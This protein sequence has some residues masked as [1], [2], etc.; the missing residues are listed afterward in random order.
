MSASW[1]D[2]FALGHRQL[3]M[4]LRSGCAKASLARL[5]RVVLLEDVTIN[6]V[7]AA[8]SPLALSVWR[9]RTGV[10]ELP[11]LARPIGWTAWSARVQVDR[12]AL[13]K[14]ANAVQAATR[15]FLVTAPPAGDDA[16]VL[17]ALLVMLRDQS[18]A[19]SAG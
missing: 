12:L 4:S 15:E 11:L 6:G 13:R 10:S 1:C 16:H 2:A 3:N 7:L 9:G 17:A 14:Y 5:A 18:R 8:R 19:K